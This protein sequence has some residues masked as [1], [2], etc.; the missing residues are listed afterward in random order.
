MLPFLK[1]EAVS[2]K[3]RKWLLFCITLIRQK[4]KK[5]TWFCTEISRFKT[6]TGWQIWRCTII[7]IIFWDFLTSYQIFFSPQVKLCAISTYKHGMHEWTIGLPNNLRLHE[8]TTERLNDPSIFAAG[9]APRAPAPSPPPTQK[10]PGPQESR[11]YQESQKTPQ[12][13]NPLFSLPTKMKALL[14]VTIKNDLKNRN[15]TFPVGRHFTWK[16]Q[17]VPNIL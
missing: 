2:C 15:L 4:K 6:L 7:F 8:L 11:K 5:I 17:L 14:I 10:D 1:I 3:K 13:N 16:L 9:R 12:N